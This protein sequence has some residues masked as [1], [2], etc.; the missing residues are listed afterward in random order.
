[1]TQT[2]EKKTCPI[3]LAAWTGHYGAWDSGGNW[4]QY[5]FCGSDCAWYDEVIGACGL[6]DA[7]R[8]I[9]QAIGAHLK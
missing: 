1:M 2:D 8:D 6:I 4:E 3:L 7:I 5:V 9:G